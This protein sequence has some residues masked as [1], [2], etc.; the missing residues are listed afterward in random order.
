M[1][2][3]VIGKQIMERLTKS[4]TQSIFPHSIE[5]VEYALNLSEEEE[6][7]ETASFRFNVQK[8]PDES[9][10][11]AIG[12]IHNVD[13]QG[14][15]SLNVNFHG[16]G[17]AFYDTQNPPHHEAPYHPFAPHSIARWMAKRLQTGHTS[18][19]SALWPE[20]TEEQA[21]FNRKFQDLLINV[22]ARVI[23]SSSLV[24]QLPYPDDVL[25]DP[26]TPH[27]VSMVDQYRVRR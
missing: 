22:I 18:T 16:L 2:S 24:L 15:H 11:I 14:R 27:L 19:N 25:N 5:L 21:R 26:K 6:Q 9:Y 8:T 12:V 7:D 1:T 3:T 23:M 17:D 13:A 10:E 4:A 20:G